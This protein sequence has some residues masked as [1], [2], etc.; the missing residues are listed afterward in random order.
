MILLLPV[1][2]PYLK[3]PIVIC[4]AVLSVEF[5]NVIRVNPLSS[6]PRTTTIFGDNPAY[7]YTPGL[8]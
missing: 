4:I 1:S 8:L 2:V 5:R 7:L 3:Q 6:V